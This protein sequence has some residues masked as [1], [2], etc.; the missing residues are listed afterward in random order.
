[1]GFSEREKELRNALERQKKANELRKLE[2]EKKEKELAGKNLL[3]VSFEYT[4][5]DFESAMIK[6]KDA[7]WR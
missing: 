4:P 7:A 6:L 1:M 5:Q 3:K 2:N